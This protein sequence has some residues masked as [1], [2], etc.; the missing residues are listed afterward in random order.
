MSKVF[1]IAFKLGGEITSSF[2]DAFGDA[3]NMMKTLGAAAVALGGADALTGAIAQVSEMQDSLAKLSAQTGMYGTDMESFGEIAKNVFRGGYGESFDEVTAALANVKQNMHNLDAGELERMTSNAMIFADTF[4]SDINEITRASQNMMENF[5][6]SSEKSMDLFATGMQRG[7]NFS[8]EMLDNVAEYAPLFSAMGYSAEEYFGILERGSQ[9]GVYNLDFLQDS[10][11]EFQIR[12]KDGSK[13]TA[14][15]M[16]LMSKETQGVWKDFMNGKGTVADVASTVIGELKGMENQIEAGQI[17]V[18]LFGTK[19]EDLEADAMYAMLGSQGAMEDFEGAMEKVNAVRFDTFGAAIKGIGRILFMDIVYPLGEAVL[20]ILNQLANYLKDNLPEAITTTVATL[21][22]IT[23]I[24]VGM[25]AAFVTYRGTL[26]I[27]SSA[28]IAFNAVQKISILL[29][30]AHR[31]AMIAYALYGGG[32]TGVIASIRAAMQVLNVTMLANPFVAVAAAVVGVATAFVV[33][34]KMSDKFRNAVN[35]TFASVKSFVINSANYIATNAVIIWNGLIESAK[36]LPS[37]L[38]TALSGAAIGKMVSGLFGDGKGIMEGL[39]NSIKA[40]FS[41]IPGIISMVAPMMA[42]LGLSFLG[43]SGP[44]GWLIGAIVSIGGFLFRLAQTNDGVASS[45]SKAWESIK[46]AFAPIMQVLSDGI[47]QF[48]EGVGP[49]LAKTMAVISQSIADMAPAFADLGGTLGELATLLLSTW[50]TVG[51]TIATTVLPLLLQV[52]QTVFPAIISIIST[53]IPIVLGLLMSIVPIVLE[54][55]QMVIPLIL[56]VI[57]MV[58]PMI[59]SIIQMVLPIFTSLLTMVASVILTL[60]QTVIPLILSVVQMVFPMVLGIIQMVIPL[61]TTILQTLVTI[62]NGVIVPAINGILA[63]V[64]FVFPYIQLVI[65]NALMIVNGII[66]AAMALLKGDWEGA[67]NSIKATAE[68]IMNNIISFFQGINLFEVGKSIVTGLINGIKSMGGAVIGAV[69]G[70][71]PAPIKGVASK[72]LGSL[73]GFAEGGIVSAPTLAWIG[74]GGDTET[75]IPWNNSERSKNLWLQTGQQLGMLS[76]NG[77]LNDI[78]QQVNVQS[79][80]PSAAGIKPSQIMTNN[81]S[82]VSSP[83]VNFS[84]VYNINGGNPAEVQ[85]AIETS[86]DDLVTMIKDILN[87]ERRVA[88]G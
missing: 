13:G 43:V 32:L 86:Q 85:Q 73:P 20:P 47:A 60:A 48:A 29:Y 52:F 84:P 51:T 21:K 4:D 38:A 88:F 12:V 74:E 81:Q 45:L 17:A 3:G 53:V 49:Q 15:A 5:G 56:S 59:L 40:G 75:V 69:S 46:T 54:I 14:D 30:N 34:Y 31:A 26:A 11:K 2:K 7:L 76:K 78:Q 23:P 70:M 50:S 33:A 18:G 63:V 42:T 35:S 67:W 6:V 68:T 72:L 25:T 27:V 87:N 58:F 41:S 1:E 82:S 9:A 36:S 64:Q 77:V 24:V 80:A 22:A 71:I 57:Q 65:T 61:I 19:F 8:D 39:I 79:S 66:Q 83:Q 62:I 44:I 55:A 10:M 37:L 16:A 28:Q